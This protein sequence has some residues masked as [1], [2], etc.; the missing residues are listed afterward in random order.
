MSDLAYQ[1]GV[2]PT[3]EELAALYG[4]VGWSTY[5]SDAT[6]LEAAVNASLAVVTA[7]QDGELLGLARL[8]GDGLT[9]VYLQDILVLPSHQRLG[10]GRQL[11][12]RIL[13]PFHD[14]R[15]KVLITDDEP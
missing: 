14:V 9:I 3:R 15:Q 12:Q 7:R 6:R 2:I 5:T 1:S 10:I 13:A 4:S 11:F 8:V